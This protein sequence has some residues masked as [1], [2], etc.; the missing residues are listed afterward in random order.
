MKRLVLLVSAIMLVDTTFFTALTPLLPHYADTLGLS[1]AGAGVLTASFGIGT[2]VGSIPAGMLAARVGPKPVVLLG[3][4]LLASTSLA[5]G[6]GTSVW[7]LTAARFLQG[8]GGACT[9]GGSLSWLAAVAPPERRGELIGT[10]LGAGIGGALLGP[11]LGAAAASIGTKPAFTGVAVIGG[12]IAA[13]VVAFPAPRPDVPQ[14]LSALRGRIRERSLVLGMW[15]VALAAILFGTVSVL[16]PLRLDGLGFGAAAIGAAFLLSAALEAALS[17]ALGRIADRRGPAPV[18]RGALVA[19]AFVAFAFPW[20]ESAWL[21]A[22]LIVLGGLAFGGFWVPGL[23][24]LASGADRTGL[25]QSFAFALMNLAW[26]SGEGLGSLAG[27]TMGQHLGD[28]V[29]YCACAGL[30]LVTLFAAGLT[31]AG[32]PAYSEST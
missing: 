21:V 7:V 30:C 19:S 9:W 3:L 13:A 26:A 2:L 29:P 16:A 15:L 31:R 22:G 17:P 1:K 25:D 14:T 23:A 32:S 6:F 8:V 28:A 10:A 5:F 11:A 4:G 18:A 12:A 24:L 20:P 27:G